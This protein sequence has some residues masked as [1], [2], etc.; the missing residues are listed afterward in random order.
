VRPDEQLSFSIAPC[1]LGYLSIAA[2]DR[3][4]CAISLSDPTIEDSPSALEARLYAQFPDAGLKRDDARLQQWIDALLAH[5]GGNCFELELSLDV[6]GT[7]F[8]LR[9]WQELRSIPY[10]ETRTYS[11]IAHAI[12]QPNAV[13]A[14]GGACGANRVALAIPCHRV[15]REGGKISGFRWGSEK[16]RILLQREAEFSGKALRLSA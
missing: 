15:V 16:K 11:Q 4:I 8:Q 9:V 14:V 1:P 5:L 3:G 2:T 10:V 13:R 6:P 7:P 12:G